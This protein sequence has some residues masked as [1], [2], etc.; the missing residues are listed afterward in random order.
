MLVSINTNPASESNDDKTRFFNFMSALHSV[1][2]C[3]AGGTPAAVR[4]VRSSDGTKN[5][6]YNCITVISNTEAGGWT[7]GVSN[8]ITTAT[9]YNASNGSAYIVDLYNASGKS[10]Y[11]YYRQTFGNFSYVF[12]SSFSS[13]PQLEYFQGCTSSDPSSVVYSSSGSYSDQGAAF[14]RGTSQWTSSPDSVML[15]V[16]RSTNTTIYVA[17]TANYLIITTDYCMAYFGIR[18]QAGWELTRNDNPPWVAFGF[19]GAAGNTNFVNGNGNHWDYYHTWASRISP[20]GVQTSPAKLG[21]QR[22]YDAGTTAHAITANRHPSTDMGSYWGLNSSSG[23]LQPLFSLAY[24][25]NSGTGYSSWTND[26]PTTDSVTG[27]SVP[28]AYPLMYRYSDG[29]SASSGRMPGCYKG[30]AST[31]AGLNYTV[32]ASEYTIGGEAYTPVRTG[33]PTYPDLFF[34]RKA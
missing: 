32:T 7:A 17:V 26:A 27:L 19:C 21:Q 11:P 4:P 30:M 8:N 6:N 28:P 13:Y 2:T 22:Q 15:D 12:S 34:L 16:H 33:H 3:A 23:Y 31:L 18:D 1:A 9:S 20:V 14:R 24:P 5:I 29:S 10:T 25:T